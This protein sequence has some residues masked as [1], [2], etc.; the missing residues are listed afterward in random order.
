[1][2]DHF[3]LALFLK[4]INCNKE[5]CHYW[6]KMWFRC[7]S[8]IHIYN[9]T[10]TKEPKHGSF[11]VFLTLWMCRCFNGQLKVVKINENEKRTNRS[12]HNYSKQLLESFIVSPF[13]NYNF[14]LNI[15]YTVYIANSTTMPPD[16]L[17]LR[18][19]QN[20][21]TTHPMFFV[22]RV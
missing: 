16:R 6:I 20:L 12:F 14:Q 13:H 22:Q 1:M 11:T 10:C 5:I 15:L 8:E 9:L 2:F 4:V 17:S 3:S 18:S 19:G 7:E 21:S